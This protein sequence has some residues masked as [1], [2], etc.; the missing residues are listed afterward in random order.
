MLELFTFFGLLAFI[1]YLAT[2]LDRLE[3][4][5]KAL[6][7]EWAFQS[8]LNEHWIHPNKQEEE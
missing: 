7:E 1:I 8:D 6:E 4:R 5:L 2:S 3:R